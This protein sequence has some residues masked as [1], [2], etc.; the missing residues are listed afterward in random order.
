MPQD[1]MSGFELRHRLNKIKMKPN[2]NPKRLFPDNAD[3]AERI[4]LRGTRVQKI[5]DSAKANPDMNGK[6]DESKKFKMTC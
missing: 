5:L 4:R 1:K 3:W 2:E 6:C